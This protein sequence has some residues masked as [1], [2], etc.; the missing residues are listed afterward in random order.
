MET[1][2]AAVAGRTLLIVEDEILS[3]MSLQD[4]L[5]DAGY[6]VLDLTGRYQEAVQ[7]A[8][9]DKPDLALVNIQ[10][11][12]RDDG[13]ALA[14]EFKEMGIPVLFIS[15][16]AGRARS[17]RTAAVGSLPKPYSPSDM[18]KAVDYLLRHLAGDETVSPPAALEVFETSVASL[19]PDDA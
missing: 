11:H 10:L 13:V 9:A 6:R 3:A 12:G 16:Q 1:A 7:A 14:G 5:E 17:A 18:V 19:A 2:R 15:G 8:R 4:A